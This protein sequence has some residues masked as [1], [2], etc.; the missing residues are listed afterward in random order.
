MNRLTQITARRCGSVWL[1]AFLI[2]GG[3]VLLVALLFPAISC[4]PISAEVARSEN[5]VYLLAVALKAFHQEYGRFPQIRADGM[6]LDEKSQ[7]AL[8]R[9][10]KAENTGENPRKVVFFEGRLARST[11][12]WIRTRHYRQGLSPVSGALLDPW[13]E[14]YRVIVDADGDYR[15][16]G[17]YSDEAP[18]TTTAVIVWSLG[19]DGK[20]S[21]RWKASDYDRA[22]DIVS[23]R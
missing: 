12:G 5:D 10:L 15:I 3:V 16:T 7:G 2:L 11:G 22:D 6:Y 18:I 13:G 21:E 14:A 8:L 9:V 20:Q 4:G 23:W 17:P 19:E 1:E